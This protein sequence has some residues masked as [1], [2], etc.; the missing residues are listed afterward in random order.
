MTRYFLNLGLICGLLLISTSTSGANTVTYK[1]SVTIPAIIGFNV[2]AEAP[3]NF[4]T[5]Q[6]AKAIDPNLWDIT[7]IEAVRGEEEIL[8]RTITA[9]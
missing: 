1:I 6:L 7:T 3:Q 4:D 2:P 9:K 5:L 8:L